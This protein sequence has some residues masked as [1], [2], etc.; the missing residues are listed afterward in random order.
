MNKKSNVKRDGSGGVMKRVVILEST[1]LGLFRIL[2]LT[3]CVI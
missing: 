3:S 2:S 1:Y